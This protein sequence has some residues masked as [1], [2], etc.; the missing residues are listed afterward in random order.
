M[1][2]ILTKDES[3]KALSFFL[4]DEL[5]VDTGLMCNLL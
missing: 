4:N 1:L 2:R 5:S 3:N